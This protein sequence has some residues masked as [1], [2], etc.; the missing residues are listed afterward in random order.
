[1]GYGPSE[2]NDNTELLP[3]SNGLTPK[4]SLQRRM[5]FGSNGIE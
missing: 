3:I 5:G 1:M 4:V 2:S